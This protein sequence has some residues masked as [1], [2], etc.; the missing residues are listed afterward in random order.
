MRETCTRPQN[1]EGKHTQFHSVEKKTWMTTDKR[2]PFWLR[3]AKQKRCLC[4]EVNKLPSPKCKGDPNTTQHK[5]DHSK[6]IINLWGK[7]LPTPSVTSMEENYVS[8]TRKNP[9]HESE[10]DF[11]SCL[12]MNRQWRGCVLR[13]SGMRGVVIPLPIVRFNPLVECACGQGLTVLPHST[14]IHNCPN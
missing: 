7:Y 2:L 12:R 13:E 14:P 1:S 9:V 8:K 11:F 10:K 6:P 4:V 5:G 3:E